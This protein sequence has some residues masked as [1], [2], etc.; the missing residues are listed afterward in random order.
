MA[1]T[2]QSGNLVWQKVKNTLSASNVASV[3]ANPASQRAFLDALKPYL[4]NQKRNFDMYFAPIDG[5]YS[6]SD[7][8]NNASQV[9]VDAACTLYAIWLVKKGSTETCFKWTNHAST[10]ATNGTQDGV[11]SATAAGDVFQIFP[12]GRALSSGLTVT[13]NTTR[14]GSTLTLA[15]NQMSGFAIVG[16]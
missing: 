9:L 12:G 10:A 7:G 14:T 13:E 8:G 6:S 15:A 4:A 16:A 1:L 3:G 2:T 5:V 11:I